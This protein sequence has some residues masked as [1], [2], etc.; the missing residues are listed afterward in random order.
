LLRHAIRTKELDGCLVLPDVTDAISTSNGWSIRAVEWD[1]GDPL[2]S[3]PG[4]VRQMDNSI[5]AKPRYPLVF[6]WNVVEVVVEVERTWEGLVLARKGRDLQVPERSKR[7]WSATERAMG[8]K[9]TG[10]LW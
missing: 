3:P 9:K 6:R 2:S 8:R 4:S 5:I 7:W 1:I 10:R